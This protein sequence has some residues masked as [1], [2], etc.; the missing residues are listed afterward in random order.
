MPVALN[1]HTDLFIPEKSDGD[2]KPR[3]NVLK[4]IDQE[5]E[6]GKTL[7]L[8]WKGLQVFIN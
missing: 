6:N 2:G 5:E 3:L 7:V 4:Q 1:D 8:K